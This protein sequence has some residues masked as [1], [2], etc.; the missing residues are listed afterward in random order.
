MIWYFFLYL[1]FCLHL[2]GV[3]SINAISGTDYW[4]ALGNYGTMRIKHIAGL[5]LV[6]W[7]RFCLIDLVSVTDNC[8]SQSFLPSILYRMKW[9]QN[10]KTIIVLKLSTMSLS[11]VTCVGTI[12]ALGRCTLWWNNSKIVISFPVRNSCL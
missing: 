1:T 2:T 5:E 9:T 4:R 6:K 10:C 7:C 12:Q 3:K 11:W 8:H